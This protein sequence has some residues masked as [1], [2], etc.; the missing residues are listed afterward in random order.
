MHYYTFIKLNSDGGFKREGV[1]LNQILRTGDCVNATWNN[2]SAGL[3]VILDHYDRFSRTFV[4][5]WNFLFR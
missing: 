5:E 3:T 1:N 2:L 4:C